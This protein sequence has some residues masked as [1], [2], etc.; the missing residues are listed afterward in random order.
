MG[1]VGAGRRP[2]ER[3]ADAD[4][5]EVRLGDAVQLVGGR[6]VAQSRADAGP[7]GAVE[8]RGEALQLLAIERDVVDEH[9]V[10][11]VDADLRCLRQR[12]EPRQR[13]SHG[14][15]LAIHPGVEIG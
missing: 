9:L 14:H 8:E 2:E 7:G 12:F 10:D 3:V 1:D 5:I 11:A 6:G 4:G 15:A 13:P